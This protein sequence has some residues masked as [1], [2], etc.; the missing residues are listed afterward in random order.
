[1]VVR[2]PDDT[3]P[4]GG[5]AISSCSHIARRLIARSSVDPKPHH[6]PL[7]PTGSLRQPTL[8]G[9]GAFW[10][11]PMRPLRFRTDIPRS[12]SRPGPPSTVFEPRVPG[13]CP[14]FRHPMQS[15]RVRSP[16]VQSRSFRCECARPC[17][18]SRSRHRG[19]NSV[20]D[21]GAA[22]GEGIKEP[23]DHRRES[24]RCV[25]YSGE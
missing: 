1:M 6:L 14:E 20:G 15:L 16:C 9:H 22:I 3:G 11:F 21:L 8:S 24:L 19:S 12:H 18:E 7:I 13:L 17:L 2:W 10:R 25:T 23:H 4:Q 5:A